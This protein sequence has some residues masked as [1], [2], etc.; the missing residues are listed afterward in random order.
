MSK[1]VIF[2]GWNR[3]IPGREKE[4]AGHF[5]EFM[6]LVIQFQ[7]EGTIDSF[8]PVLLTAHGGD[9]NGFVLIRGEI[10]KLQ[11]LK[12]TEAWRTHVTRAIL[13]TEGFGVIDGV[14]GE[15]V[16]EQME[17]WASLIPD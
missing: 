16:S 13:H 14:T 6:A 2:I 12:S 4:S 11:E 3:P 15:G 10:S 7:Q 1:N 17:L 8:E 9:L 5:Q